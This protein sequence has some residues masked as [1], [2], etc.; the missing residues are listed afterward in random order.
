MT[1]FLEAARHI[2]HRFAVVQA[3]CENLTFV[4]FFDSDFSLDKCSGAFDVGDVDG[5]VYFDFF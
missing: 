4:K 2:L 5:I 1:F 3:D